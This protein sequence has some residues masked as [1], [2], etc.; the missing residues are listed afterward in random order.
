M[1]DIMD[2]FSILY[3]FFVWPQ[4]KQSSGVKSRK[5]YLPY[6]PPMAILALIATRSREIS[7][8]TYNFSPRYRPLGYLPSLASHIA[9]H[10]N[11][12][13]FLGSPITAALLSQGSWINT[14]QRLARERIPDTT[15]EAPLVWWTFTW[16]FLVLF[17]VLDTTLV[18]SFLLVHVHAPPL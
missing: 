9:C 10:I 13:F 15:E 18:E 4:K 2:I 6:A 3:T 17:M 14:A 1:V 11:L 12:A 5:N 7:L 8:C 16:A